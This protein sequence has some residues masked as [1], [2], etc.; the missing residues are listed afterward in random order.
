MLMMMLIF[1]LKDD[2]HLKIA[3]SSI[4][5]KKVQGEADK[6][7]ERKQHYLLISTSVNLIGKVPISKE[8]DSATQQGE[9]C[10]GN[11]LPKGVI[12]TPSY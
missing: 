6:F 4:G 3:V 10:L 12:T 11:D 9:W 1:L 8:S 2:H 7:K 5:L